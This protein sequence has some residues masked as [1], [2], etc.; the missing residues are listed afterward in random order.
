MILLEVTQGLSTGITY[1]WV[2]LGI[3]ISFIIPVI[4]KLP[5]ANP[6]KKNERGKYWI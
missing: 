6:L 2:V 1:L 3:L 5:K 4:M